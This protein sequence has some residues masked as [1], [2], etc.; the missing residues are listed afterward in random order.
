MSGFPGSSILVEELEQRT[1]VLPFPHKAR[2]QLPDDGLSCN[3]YIVAS[4]QIEYRSTAIV[5]KTMPSERHDASAL[6]R[7]AIVALFTVGSGG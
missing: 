3:S 4:Y 7:S 6:Q 1:T 2:E 5:P